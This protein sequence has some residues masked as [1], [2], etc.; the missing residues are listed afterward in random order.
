[1]KLPPGA[2]VHGTVKD[3]NGQPVAGAGI[4]FRAG[5]DRDASDYVK[6]NA[7]GRYRFDYLCHLPLSA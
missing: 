2:S 1:M 6:S 5:A 3:E 7:Q 4:S